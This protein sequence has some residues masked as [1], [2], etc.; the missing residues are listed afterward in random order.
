MSLRGV[1]TRGRLAGVVL[2]VV[3]LAGAGWTWFGATAVADGETATVTRGVYTDIVEIRGQVQPVRSTYVTAPYNAGELQ[4]VKMA[5]NGT[6]VKDGDV[7]AEFDA[8]TLRR[9]IRRSSR[10]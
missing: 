4:I 1:F 7:V 6:T 8:V 2:A 9:T 10:S 3:V 5:S